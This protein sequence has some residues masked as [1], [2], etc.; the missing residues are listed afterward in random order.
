MVRLLEI[1]DLEH[2][3]ASNYTKQNLKKQVL[4][5]IFAV[6]ITREGL[7]PHTVLL[8]YLQKFTELEKQGIDI[9]L[10]FSVGR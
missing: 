10:R 9:P 3:T 7:E 8:P 4:E 6:H 2:L 1:E 5:F